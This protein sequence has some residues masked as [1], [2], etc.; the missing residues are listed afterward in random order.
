M[1]KFPDWVLKYKKKGTELREIRGCY[2]VYEVSSKWDKE[3]KRP[4]KITGSYLGRI[5]EAEGFIPKKTK[6]VQ[7]DQK[8]DAPI[9]SVKETGIT[10]FIEINL[11]LYISLLRKHFP[12]N[13]QSILALV[14]GRFVESSPMK[15]MKFHYEN[16]YISELYPEAK[17]SKNSISKLLKEL[18][19]DRTSIVEFLKEFNQEDD[20]IIFDGTDLVSN[21]RKMDFPKL[22][23]TKKGGFDFLFNI[24]FIFSVKSQLPIYYRILPR[25]IKDVKSFKLSLLESNITDA[26]I[27]LDKGFYSENNIKELRNENLNYLISLRRNNKLIDYS[28][29]GKGVKSEFD[30]YFTYEDKIIWHK[31]SYSEKGKIHTFLSDELKTEE[32]SDYLKR[33]KTHPEK[34][35]IKDF[36]INVKKFGTLSILTNTDK[37]AEEIYSFYKNRNQVELMI[38]AFKNLIDADNSYMQNEFSLEA[39]MFINYIALHWYYVILNK[40]KST[41][42]NYKY[43][44]MDLVKFLKEIKR[45]KFNG[46]W[47]NAEITAKTSEIIE[48]LYHIT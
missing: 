8:A 48:K 3:L 13:W 28:V 5:T 37:T 42:L 23:K 25:N 4:R 17:I 7:I 38:D 15:N 29:F 27:V 32:S 26:L 9:L 11:H 41:N 30:G 46:K 43:S 16:S 34:Y 14:Y 24:M 45:V 18:G 31:I 36:H 1:S 2:Y 12:N 10:D 39:W 19:R 20:K 6:Q 47:Y 21:S 22:S 33:I 44:P 35:S 40:L